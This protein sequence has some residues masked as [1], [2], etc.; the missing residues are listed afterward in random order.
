MSAIKA[1]RPRSLS[2]KS[3]GFTL[4]EVVVALVIVAVAL[5]ALLTLVSR[6]SDNTFRLRERTLAEW[7]AH[8]QLQTYRINHQLTGRVLDGRQTGA[9]EFAGISWYWVAEAEDTAVEDMIRINIAV[10]ADENDLRDY[11]TATLSAFIYK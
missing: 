8:D 3:K 10:A 1:F 9:T 5:P 2:N 4:I 11:P 6:Q 7:V